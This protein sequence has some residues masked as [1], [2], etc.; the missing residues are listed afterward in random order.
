MSC[1]LQ[2]RG[3]IRSIA[4]N[5]YTKHTQ[6]TE[7]FTVISRTEARRRSATTA[8]LLFSTN[9]SFRAW[10]LTATTIVP[11]M[12][13]LACLLA[14]FSLSRKAVLLPARCDLICFMPRA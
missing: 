12:A 11:V 2:P 8:P 5:F 6:D 14:Q 10:E 9:Y 4:I 7:Y 3:K 1:T 13:V